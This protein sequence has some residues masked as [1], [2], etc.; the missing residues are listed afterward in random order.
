MIG[1]QRNTIAIYKELEKEGVAAEKLARV[2]AQSALTLALSHLKK[3]P[4][5]LWLNLSPGDATAHAPSTHEEREAVEML[6]I[7]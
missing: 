1:S 3:L 4:S 7:P 2:Y 5:P 6:K